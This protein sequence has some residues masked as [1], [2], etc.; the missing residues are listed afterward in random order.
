MEPKFSSAT[1]MACKL[2]TLLTSWNCILLP[3][4]ARQLGRLLNLERGVVANVRGVASRTGF[5]VHL[6]EAGKAPSLAV[7]RR[8]SMG[9]ETIIC[10]LKIPKK[11]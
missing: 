6:E 4:H 5:G 9:W 10:N 8:R 7:V 2:H 3:R 1:H 11:M